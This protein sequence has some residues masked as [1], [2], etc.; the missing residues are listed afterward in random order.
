MRRRAGSLDAVTAAQPIPEGIEVGLKALASERPDTAHSG[1]YR[2]EQGSIDLFR[3][4]LI[5]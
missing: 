5:T 3:R 2:I 1:A 4:Q